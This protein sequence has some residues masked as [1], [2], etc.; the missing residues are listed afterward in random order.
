MA[1]DPFIDK[2]V[3]NDGAV[4]LE[5]DW[6]PAE[7]ASAK[8]KFVNTMINEFGAWLTFPDQTGLH[9]YAA[10]MSRVLLSAARPRQYLQRHHI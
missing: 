2:Q 10:S 5:K 8:R 6:T 9:D 3:I 4:L 7:E 1:A